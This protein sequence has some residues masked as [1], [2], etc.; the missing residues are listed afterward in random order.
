MANETTGMGSAAKAEM[1]RELYGYIDTVL[2]EKD[3][4][5]ELVKE[6]LLVH[7]PEDEFAVV[8]VT[9]KKKEAFDL[10]DAR[11]EYA[12][13]LAKEKERREALEKAAAK[14]AEK[15]AKA[16]EKAAEKAK[17]EKNAEKDS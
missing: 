10:A 9:I 11:Q 12:E 16:A 3:F 13:K 4:V 6:G 5:T 2:G 8:K 1:R 17:K 14:K 7:L 15:E